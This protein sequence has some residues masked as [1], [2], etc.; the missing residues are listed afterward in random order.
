MLHR[1]HATLNGA[2]R[3]GLISMNP[4]RYPELP[5]AA[6]PRPSADQAEAVLAGILAATVP[7]LARARVS[8]EAK[9]ALGRL[10][11]AYDREGRRPGA[12]P[13]CA[14]QH[15]ALQR[16]ALARAALLTVAKAPDAFHPAV[17]QIGG[18]PYPAMYQVLEEAPRY[19]HWLA[20]QGLFGTI[21]PC[22]A[23]TVAGAQGAGPHEPGLAGNR[24]PGG[25][26]ARCRRV[27]GLPQRPRDR[28]GDRDNR[29]RGNGVGLCRI[30]THGLERSSPV[31]L[32]IRLASSRACDS[33]DALPD[34]RPPDRLDGAPGALGGVEGRRAAGAASRSRGA[35]PAEPRAQAGLG[36][37]DGARRPGP[38]PARH[39]PPP[40]KPPAA[41]AVGG[42]QAGQQ[43]PGRNRTD[44]P[45]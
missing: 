23:A 22:G 39:Q 36:R 28:H 10:L 45:G 26:Q 43:R 17:R 13:D 2:A 34:L 30:G 8:D 19:L 18:V 32:I 33:T 37:S 5:R 15:S 40:G 4:G 16:G 12:R 7:K 9:T 20:C 24:T 29:R 44:S 31:V 1:I 35:A 27:P 42:Q 11:A 25:M 6:R 21:H 41:Q 3:A 14:Q 38:A